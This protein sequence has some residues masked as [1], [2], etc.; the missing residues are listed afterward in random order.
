MKDA[1]VHELEEANRV[2]Y[3]RDAESLE[4]SPSPPTQYM[5]SPGQSRVRKES[6]IGRWMKEEHLKRTL[7]SHPTTHPA[8]RRRRPARERER[9]TEG[10]D[11]EHLGRIRTQIES[12]RLGM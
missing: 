7:P 3:R 1:N 11:S 2:R 5:Y 4:S 10:G 12:S 8:P 9:R 6:D